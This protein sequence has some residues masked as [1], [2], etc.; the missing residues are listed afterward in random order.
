MNIEK[1][2]GS[3][4]ESDVI[5]LHIIVRSGFCCCCCF[6]MIYSIFH[7]CIESDSI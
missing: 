6:S 7:E 5:F 2:E 3:Q 4:G 1:V